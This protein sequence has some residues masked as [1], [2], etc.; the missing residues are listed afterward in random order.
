MHGDIYGADQGEKIGCGE[1]IGRIIGYVIVI[2]IMATL[3]ITINKK[4][5]GT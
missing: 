3:A 5:G 4:G 2:G 1:V